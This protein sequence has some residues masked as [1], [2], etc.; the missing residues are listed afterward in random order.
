MIVDL[1]ETVIL[2][3][4]ALPAEGLIDGRDR[5][6]PEALQVLH[7]SGMT[8]AAGKGGMFGT[9][10]QGSDLGMTIVALFPSVPNPV[11]PG[12][13]LLRRGKCGNQQCKTEQ[14]C[15]GISNISLPHTR[16]SFPESRFDVQIVFLRKIKP[17]IS[18]KYTKKSHETQREDL[19]AQPL[20]FL[21][22]AAECSRHAM[23]GMRT[24]RPL[25]FFL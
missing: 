7:G 4:V 15:G 25:Q 10:L 9:L 16:T 6:V 11:C 8:G 18:E 24:G 17:V 21:A 14:G 19:P 12:G 23:S 5:L 13:A 20:S 2:I 3:A 1:S 22:C